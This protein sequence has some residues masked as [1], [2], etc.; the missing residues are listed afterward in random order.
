ME[1]KSMPVVRISK[2]KFA[3]DKLG[4]AERLLEE[5]GAAARPADDDLSYFPMLHARAR[6]RAARGDVA[7]ARSDF[8]ALGRRRAR[9]NSELALI[10]AL[11]AAPEVA[12]GD[13]DALEAHTG[14]M[15]RDAR[16][17]GT[18]R[19][20]GMALRAAGLAEGGASG[21]EL[22]EEAAATL[23]RSP[24]RVE[25][26]RALADFG[27]ALRRSGRRSDAREPLRAAL[28]LAD[29]CGA[30]PVAERARQELRAAGARPRRPRMTGADALTPSERRTASMAAAGLSNP[31]IAQAL[32]VTKKTVE[33]HLGSAYRKLGIRS[34]AELAGALRDA[35]D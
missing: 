5:S 4:D 15:L 21:L 32:F 18:P 11:L 33:A 25:H 35:R 13:R 1:E 20:I 7:G 23:E 26:A 12:D 27:A 8:E 10:P 22:L 31:E 24:A 29:S 17:W 14:E 16:S 3:P 6:L 30:R 34:R 2:G 19:A 9:W 28:D